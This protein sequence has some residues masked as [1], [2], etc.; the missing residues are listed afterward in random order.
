MPC[1]FSFHC[2][3]WNWERCSKRLASDPFFLDRLMENNQQT[4]HLAWAQRVTNTHPGHLDV[5]PGLHRW[6]KAPDRE[7]GWDGNWLIGSE[8]PGWGVWSWHEA[9]CLRSHLA[10]IISKQWII[11]EGWDQ[12][13]WRPCCSM[14]HWL[15]LLREEAWVSFTE[16][17]WCVYSI[18]TGNTGSHVTHWL[19]ES[20]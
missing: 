4:I 12:G 7:V 18:T 2:G 5:H 17:S 20:T 10:E 11:S 1:R 15:S 16:R 13:S 14:T 6:G 19:W 3:V 9:H 8:T